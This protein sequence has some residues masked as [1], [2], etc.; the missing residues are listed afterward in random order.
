M[1]EEGIVANDPVTGTRVLLGYDS[2]TRTVGPI[3]KMFDSATNKW[4]ALSGAAKAG[5]DFVDDA[6]VA[7]LQTFAAEKYLTVTLVK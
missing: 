5:I 4:I 1:T 6:K 7:V 3:S 2:V